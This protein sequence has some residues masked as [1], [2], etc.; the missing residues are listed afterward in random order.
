MNF[1]AQG[2]GQGR[3]AATV[4][5]ERHSPRCIHDVARVDF[6][7]LGVR[8]KDG[9]PADIWPLAQKDEEGR[10]APAGGAPGATEEVVLRRIVRKGVAVE[11]GDAE[12]RL[13]GRGGLR[14]KGVYEDWFELISERLDVA[15]GDLLRL[16][17]MLEGQDG[18]RVRQAVAAR[19]G[20][21]EREGMEI[22]KATQRYDRSKK[23]AEARQHAFFRLPPAQ[24]GH[25]QWIRQSNDQDAVHSHP[26]SNNRAD[27][28]RHPSL[29]LSPLP[30]SMPP[31]SA[32][33]R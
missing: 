32:G 29:A 23:T 33:P 14:E 26:T 2:R 20:R 27:T 21:P 15:E 12:P 30:H 22:E 5:A 13:P 8:P 31:T 3:P 19:G 10:K 28:H 17:V 4:G 7:A 1:Q 9:L 25:G 18:K 24:D 6:A 16:A 11:E